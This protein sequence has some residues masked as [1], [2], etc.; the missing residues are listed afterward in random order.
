M[1]GAAHV[2]ETDADLIGPH[3]VAVDAGEGQASFLVDGVF[4][5]EK[6]DLRINQGHGHDQIEWGRNAV[7]LP[8]KLARGLRQ[9]D[10]AELHGLADL[11]GGK[12]DATCF[13]H[14]VDHVIGELS[15]IR[16]ERGDGRALLAENGFVV[17]N[18][19]QDHEREKVSLPRA[20]RN[21]IVQFLIGIGILSHSV[22]RLRHA[23]R[24]TVTYTLR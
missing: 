16:I 15:E 5:G 6:L 17:V 11:L 7:E 19:R 20:R 12:A 13:V 18:N 22:I 23:G 10:D 1:G 2:L 4:A 24:A 8:I 21:S 9:I 3:D 14:G